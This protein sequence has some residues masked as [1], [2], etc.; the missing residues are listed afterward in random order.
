M[1]RLAWLLIVGCVLFPATAWA[2]ADSGNI[3]GVVRDTSGAV[4]PGVTVEAASPALIE[5]VRSVITDSQG[6]YRIVD[7]RPGTYSVTF[8]LPGFSTVKREGIALTTGFTANVNADLKVG[9]LEETITVTGEAPVVD[10]QNVE[11][12]Q[13]LSREI[14]D[15]IPTSRRP[16]QFITLIVG[17]D[18]GANAST[19]HDVGGVGSD[20]AF[21]GVHG[22]RADDMTYNFGG[23]DSRVFS[24][25]GFQYNAHTFEEVV[26]ETAAGSAEATTGGVQINIIPKDGG[27]IF[28]GTMSAEVTGPKLQSDNINDYLRSH[29]IASAGAVRRYYDVGGG[30]GGPIRQN[31]LW[32][33]SA[34]RYEDRSL[35]QAGNYYN[36]RQGTVFYEPDLSRPAYNHDF[37]RDA[38]VRLTWQAT[39]KQKLVGSFTEHPACQ[40][41]FQLLEQISPIF[42]PEAVA[43]HHYVPQ[44]LATAHYTNPL[45]GRL[46]I[47]ADYSKSRYNREQRRIPGVGFDAISV[48]DTG[49][50]LRYG[51]RSTLYQR[52][53]DEREHERVSLSYITGTHNFKAGV[54][55]NQ[56]SQG[57]KSYNDLFLVNHAISYTFRNQLPVSV[58]IYTGPYGPYQEG[59]ENNLYA[60]DQWTI[61][62][63]T[64]NLGVR[65][66]LYDMTIPAMH[67]GPGVYVPARD[68][69][70]V[71]HSPRWASLSPRVGS[72]YDL[73]G[74][75]KTAIKWALGRYPQRNTGVAV[76]LPVSNQPTSTTIAWN[77]Q[78]FGAGDPRSG[79]FLPDCDLR[80]PLANGECGAWGDRSFGQVVGGN[81]RFAADA[82]SGFNNENYNW[83]ANVSWQ[84]QLRPNVGLTVAYFRTWYGAMQALDNQLVTPADFDPFCFTAPVDP[85]LGS[86][87]GKQFC[88]NYDVK[89]AK[90]GQI[91]YLRTQASHYGDMT[92]VFDGI[93]VT[94]NARFGKAQFQGGMSTGRTVT[95]NCNLKIDS[96]A[97]AT[98]GSPAGAAL[99]LSPV[100]LRPG[101]CNVSRPWG[102]STQVKFNVVYAL[103]WDFQAS[104]IYQN[105][106]G[107]PIR[108]S[109]VVP[110]ADIFPSLGRHLASCPSQTAAT[111]NQTYTVD[112]IPPF[113]LYGDRIQQ[114]DLR[115][116]RN[117]ALSRSRKLQGNFDIYN[118]LNASTAQNEQATYRPGP[119]NQWRNPIQIMGGRLI[120]FSAQL[121]F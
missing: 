37:S 2:Q 105:I 43:E 75:G 121:T 98:A 41:T 39:S 27:N 6:L 24:G 51:S 11:Q 49:L 89:P 54:D 117:F 64:L 113:S 1:V 95:D 8:T 65:Y 108:A 109:Y 58:S 112:L 33:F 101:F 78:F 25:G 107:V 20:R 119:A 35:Y 29:G 77:D 5:K 13:T 31:K 116:T 84:Q 85:R 110:D 66:S 34:A 93:D 74:D 9:S 81:T 88:G 100:D 83:Q 99:N 47:E 22:Q 80:N 28:S 21:F 46:L 69:P 55:L 26:V 40:C 62:R 97:T 120:K 57:E 48:T 70:E 36:K 73:F 92:E 12:Q 61:K 91:D 32:F 45:T 10:T 23:M 50:N 42:A 114:V 19:L 76:N 72:A 63:L 103:P 60:Q 71:K 59:I 38:S 102:S 18:G 111:C 53:N 87:S 7:L 3:A 4:M 86:A 16:A 90:F 30:F 17:A 67:L 14:L 94:T 15:A 56:F 44:Y 68:F 115:L 118:I 82:L 96:P 52:L 106:P 79:N 104:S